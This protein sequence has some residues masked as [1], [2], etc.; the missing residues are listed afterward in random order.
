MIFQ[1]Y[2]GGYG[3]DNYSL[4]L[5]GN[6]L[7]SFEYCGIPMPDQEKFI[8]IED[9]NNDWA[10]VMELLKKSKWKRSYWTPCCDGTQCDLE[11]KAQGLKIKS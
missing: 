8:P 2:L 7:S 10:F 4:T 1:F 3:R 11:V 9:G 6:V 5:K